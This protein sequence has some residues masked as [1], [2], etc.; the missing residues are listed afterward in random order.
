MLR[1]SDVFP[2]LFRKA[3]PV[4]SSSNPVVLA[5]SLLSV[6]GIDSLHVLGER[7]MVVR[8]HSVLRALREVKEDQYYPLLWKPCLTIAE[9]VKRISDDGDLSEVLDAFLESRFGVVCV[10]GGRSRP[11]WGLTSFSLCTER[12][13]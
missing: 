8:G 12:G 11:R 10:H 9:S 2:D 13:C 3:K 5:G 6:Y 7:G 1:I 4:V